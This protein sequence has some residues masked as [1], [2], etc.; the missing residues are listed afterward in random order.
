[1]ISA[2]FPFCADDPYT[3]RVRFEILYNYPPKGRWIVK[4]S[5]QVYVYLALF[6]DPEALVFTKSVG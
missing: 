6:T 4:R 5:V 2:E 3:E 1:M